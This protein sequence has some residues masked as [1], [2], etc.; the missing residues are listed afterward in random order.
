MTLVFTRNRVNKFT[1]VYFL[2]KYKLVHIDRKWGFNTPKQLRKESKQLP[3]A[4]TLMT[5]SLWFLFYKF[6]DNSSRNDPNYLEWEN[7]D[8]RIGTKRSMRKEC[9]KI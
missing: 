5:H 8:M 1:S 7:K 3:L 6:K 2:K 9:N 4:N